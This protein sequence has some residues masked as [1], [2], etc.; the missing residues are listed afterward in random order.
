M[1]KK[2][3]AT[4][5]RIKVF[6]DNHIRASAYTGQLWAVHVHDIV[7]EL[8]PLVY[9][10]FD[11]D[12]LDPKLC[13]HTGTPVSGGLEL[14]QITYLIRE[15]VKSGRKII[16]FDLCEV[17]PGDDEWDANVGAR[18]LFQLCSW[19]AVSQGKLALR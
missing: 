3:P 7:E 5:G 8:P 2:I 15:L 16:G 12:G 18:A 17:A 14:H 11:I 13:P 10:S 4:L 9:I 19:A 1:E 6:Y